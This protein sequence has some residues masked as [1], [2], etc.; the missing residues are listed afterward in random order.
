MGVNVGAASNAACTAG[1]Q[2]LQD[3]GVVAGQDL[4]ALI[5]ILGQAD[6]SLQVVPIAA[7]ILGTHDDIN[8]LCQL[9]NGFG[10][11]LVAGTCGDVVQHDGNIHMLCHFHVVVVHLFLRSHGEAGGDDGQDVGTQVGST[12][13]QLNGLAGGD[14]AGTCV[15]GNTALDLIHTGLDDGQLFVKGQCVGLAVGANGE[16]AVDAALDQTLDLLAEDF[17][18]HGL[19]GVHG[20]QDGGDDAFH[21]NVLHNR[22]LL[23]HVNLCFSVHAVQITSR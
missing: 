7:G 17:Q 11:Q 4:E 19:I 6:I 2:G 10:Q 20:G 8:V 13:A 9:G 3:Q 16:D 21:R 15:N 1:L 14:A 5:Q 23:F 12:L 18:V 22:F